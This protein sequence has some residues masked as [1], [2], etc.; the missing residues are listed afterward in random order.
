MVSPCSMS[1][2]MQTR[3]KMCPPPGGA[4]GG[5]VA[6]HGQVSEGHPLVGEHG[7][8]LVGE[9]LDHVPG[10]GRSRHLAG[11]V[12]E[13]DVGN[14]RETVLFGTFDPITS[15][16]GLVWYYVPIGAALAA[17]APQGRTAGIAP[18]SYARGYRQVAIPG[19][20][21]DGR[22]LRSGRRH[23]APAAPARSVRQSHIGVCSTA[24]SPP[25]SK[26]PPRY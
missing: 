1:L 19:K 9:D 22:L 10:K 11:F 8:D 18:D 24:K 23:P 5:A 6:I 15:T 26:S 16:T 4:A 14:L 25:R 7:V 3:P 2:W 12:L 20:C 21:D 13:L 17:Q